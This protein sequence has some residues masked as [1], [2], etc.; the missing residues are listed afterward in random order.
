MTNGTTTY[1]EHSVLSLSFSSVPT[2]GPLSWPSQLAP[3]LPAGSR[4]FPAGSRA[5]LACLVTLPAGLRALLA[6]SRALP[7]GTE[8]L[9]VGSGALP[10]GS[11]ALPASF[12]PILALLC[13]IGHCPLWGRSQITSFNGAT[14]AEGTADH[15]TLLRLFILIRGG[16]M[17]L[18][19]S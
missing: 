15:V 10:A 6:G 7:A 18:M 8:A 2:P 4:A 1:Q 5:L 12:K 19:L 3:G 13:T 11:R 9:S 14:E 17:R 16:I